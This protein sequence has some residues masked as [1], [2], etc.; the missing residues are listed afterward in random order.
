MK[1]IEAKESRAEI[2]SDLER[3]GGEAVSALRKFLAQEEHT[4]AD[5][6]AARVAASALSAWTRHKQTESAR[7]GTF[8]MLARELANDKA[9]FRKFV[10]IGMPNAALVRMLPDAK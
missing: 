9:E 5:V 6:G 4:S 7:E 2:V 1:P 3:L 8:L 10:K